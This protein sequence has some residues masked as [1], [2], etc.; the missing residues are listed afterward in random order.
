[1]DLGSGIRDL[2]FGKN[3]FRIPESKRHWILD[4]DPQHW[5]KLVLLR[6]SLAGNLEKPLMSLYGTEW[7]EHGY[8]LSELHEEVDYIQTNFKTTFYAPAIME[9]R[10]CCFSAWAFWDFSNYRP[11][12]D[13]H[14]AFGCISNN[15]SDCRWYFLLPEENPLEQLLTTKSKLVPLLVC[16]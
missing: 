1:M 9:C 7:R 3:L 10:L 13:A 8:G 6:L 5:C 15:L 14:D 4:P 2:G 16:M 11:R 12:L